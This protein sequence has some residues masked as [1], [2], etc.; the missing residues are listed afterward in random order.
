MLLS[1]GIYMTD[2]IIGEKIDG[3]GVIPLFVGEEE[4]KP[5]HSFGP[6]VRE[7]YIIHVC[8][9]GKGVLH[10]KFGTHKISAGELFVIRPGE[11][12]VY[13]ADKEEPWHYAW[14]AFS[15]DMAKEF[16]TGRSTYTCPIEIKRRLP[17]LVRR[18]ENSAYAYTAMIYELIYHLFSKKQSPDKLTEIK[19]YIDYNYMQDINVDKITKMFGFERSYLY[20][21]FKNKFGVGVK[22][23][24]LEVRTER[25]KQF[26]ADGYTVA[27]TAFMVG[28]R[29]EFNFSRAFKERVG[30]SPTEYK[31]RG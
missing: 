17:E 27:S 22:E 30:I 12:T 8:L 3:C 1:E 28:Y 31:K 6:Y 16:N 29:D 26:L 19:A 2:I 24:M 20:R 13:T 4:C 15:G 14:L 11:S 5:L 9:A 25:A 10:D 7:H 18:G 23:Y 21:I